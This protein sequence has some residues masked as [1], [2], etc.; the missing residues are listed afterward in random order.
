[1]E[2]E[3][4]FMWQKNKW[5]TNLSLI[6]S[7]KCTMTLHTGQHLSGQASLDY[8]N[9]DVEMS[10]ECSE[11]VPGEKYDF[12]N[13]PTVADLY[14]EIFD[15]FNAFEIVKERK[16]TSVIQPEKMARFMEYDPPED[17]VYVGIASQNVPRYVPCGVAGMRATAETRIERGDF[18]YF[19]AEKGLVRAYDPDGKSRMPSYEKPKESTNILDYW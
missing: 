14:P 1:M 12:L 9:P 19:S 2:F 18:L 3:Q 4:E 16:G 13:K 15:G 10:V 8:S 7:G 5:L 11:D 17:Y 6:T